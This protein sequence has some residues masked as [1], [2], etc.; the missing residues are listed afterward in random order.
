MVVDIIGIEMGGDDH[1]IF[2]APHLPRG[3]HTYL[4]RFFGSDLALD[5][6]LVSVVGDILPTL[7]E[8]AF[9]GNHFMISVMLGAVDAR[10][11]CRAVGFAI[12]L[13]VAN[14]RV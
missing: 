13:H 10:N 3:F 8:T 14:R 6:A 9:Y 2:R 7:T 1:L 12:V 5:K 11:E 4:M